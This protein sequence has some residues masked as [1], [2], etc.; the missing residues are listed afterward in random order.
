MA[1]PPP[2]PL[3]LTE[4]P[5]DELIEEILLRF[6]P[7]E[8]SCLLRASLVCKPWRRIISHR[9]FHRR[10]HE[11]HGR[12]PVLG[13]L[14]NNRMA[15]EDFVST[16]ASAFSLAVPGDWRAL[17]Y[18]H[19]RA[20]LLDM[21]PGWGELVLW[22]PIT[23]DQERVAVPEAMWNNTFQGDHPTAA[24][25]CAAAEC[26]HRGCH[27]KRPFHLV[28]VYSDTIGYQ[29]SYQAEEDLEWDT[30]ACSYSSETGEWS[31]VSWIKDSTSD[32]RKHTTSM[33]VGDSLL[34]FM[35]DHGTI[36]EYDLSGDDATTIS[37]PLEFQGSDSVAL[38]LTEDGGLGVAESLSDSGLTIWSR[39]VTDGNDDT[40]WVKSQVIC[41]DT[42]LEEEEEDVRPMSF[43]ERANTLF[44]RTADGIFTIELQSER[45]R[46]V[47]KDE[48]EDD[49]D[50][51]SCSLVPIE[52][53]YTPMGVSRRRSL[54]N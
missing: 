40:L 28:M 12:P 37:P 34:Y 10:L 30:W 14:L 16:T 38:I 44:F 22:D 31:D 13:F 4:S 9:R 51:D 35:S 47:Y 11:L 54:K 36:I 26:D 18:R 33:L 45:V 6:P 19:G 2:P 15:V 25:V 27:G 39:V 20:L 29:N 49:D 5:P 8:P 1:A 7:D 23:G 24:I 43:A 52:G 17:D 48:D 21:V 50:Y 32:F 41:L 46:K 3:R 42:A 53:F